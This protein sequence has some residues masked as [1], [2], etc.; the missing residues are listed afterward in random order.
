MNGCDMGNL[1]MRQIKHGAGDS[2][3]IMGGVVRD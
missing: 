1:V 3:V 2:V